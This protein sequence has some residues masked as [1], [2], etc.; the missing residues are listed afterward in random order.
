MAAV[1]DKAPESLDFCKQ[2]EVRPPR[3]EKNSDSVTLHGYQEYQL[4]RS[5]LKV[6]E[7]DIPTRTK[8]LVFDPF[9][10]RDIM[11]GKTVLDLGANGGFFSFWAAQQ[12]AAKVDAVDIDEEYVKLIDGAAKHLSFDNVHAHHKG[13]IDWTANADIVFAFAVIHWMYAC[14]PGFETMDNVV[15][16]LADLTNELLVLEWVEPNDLNCYRHRQHS[17]ASDL[18]DGTYNTAELEKSLSKHFDHF[19]KSHAVSTGRVLYIVSKQPAEIRVACGLSPAPAGA[20]VISQRHFGTLGG[21]YDWNRVYEH[22]DRIVKQCSGDRALQMAEN[23]R[24]LKGPFFPEVIETTKMDNES[25]IVLRKIDGKPLISVINKLLDDKA[26]FYGFVSDCM[27][28]LSEL[29]DSGVR[30]GSI[31]CDNILVRENRPV[32]IGGRPGATDNLENDDVYC[33]GKLLLELT[34]GRYAEL[35]DALLMLCVPN[36]GARSEAVPGVKSLARA[37]RGAAGQCKDQDLSPSEQPTARALATL[38]SQ[39]ESKELLVRSLQM[40]VSELEQ[41][42]NKVNDKLRDVLTSKA[43]KLAATLQKWRARLAG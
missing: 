34:A 3:L 2:P 18:I 33:M 41:E 38:L 16:K 32:L 14:A 22:N 26:V 11:S 19:W 21:P 8:Q 43:W 15:R 1:L 4:S 7:I 35:Q 10:Q 28:I 13:V 42:N 36:A 17:W 29:K 30:H 40:R 6:L 23:L 12:G 9:F 25:A 37:L 24:K 31:I 20:S 39:N 27:S 5:G